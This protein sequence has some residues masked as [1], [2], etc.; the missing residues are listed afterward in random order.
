MCVKVS[1]T[2]PVVTQP[3]PPGFTA[4]PQTPAPN[5]Q[6]QQPQFIPQPAAT[7]QPGPPPTTIGQ[8][9]QPMVV[10]Q[11]TPPILTE[12]NQMLPPVCQPQ[13][14]APPSAQPQFAPQPA[15]PIQ[16]VAQVAPTVDPIGVPV[17][18]QAPQQGF[19]PMGNVNGQYVQ[20][21]HQVSSSCLFLAQINASILCNVAQYDGSS[22]SNDVSNY[23][24]HTHGNGTTTVCNFTATVVDNA[25]ASTH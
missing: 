21:G 24:Q 2:K 15:P 18:S 6:Q 22:A 17:H 3:Q 11:Q 9:P 25:R 23:L 7:V 13:Y 19:V 5:Q 10:T 14:V 16:P 1:A 12:T 8:Q 4:T 20:P